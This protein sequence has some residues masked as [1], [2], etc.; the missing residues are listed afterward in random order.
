[1]SIQIPDVTEIDA[2]ADVVAR[3]ELGT[4]DGCAAK[5][6]LE[7]DYRARLSCGLKA[8]NALVKGAGVR[9]TEASVR[10]VC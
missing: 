10:P 4:P 5:L 7:R 9:S 8:P 6:G 3:I 2:P 1:M